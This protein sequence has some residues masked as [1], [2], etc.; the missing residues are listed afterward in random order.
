MLNEIITAV[1]LQFVV[2]FIQSIPWLIQTGLLVAIL[3]RQK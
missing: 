3:W 1:G 2:Y